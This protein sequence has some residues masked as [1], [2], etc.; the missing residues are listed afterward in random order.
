MEDGAPRGLSAWPGHLNRPCAKAYATLEEQGSPLRLTH[1]MVRTSPKGSRDP[2]WRRIGWDEAYRLIAGR[3]REVRERHG[4][5]SVMFYAGNPKEMRLPLSRLASAFGSANFATEDSLCYK[6]HVLASLLLFGVVI[7]A[8]TSLD[9]ARSVLLWGANPAASRP[10]MLPGLL[11]MRAR[12]ARFVVV[13]PR[14]TPTAERLADVHLRPLPGTDGALALGM[15]NV[16]ISREIYDREFV[17]RW[18]HGFDA[19]RE[20]VSRFTPERVEAM[21]RVPARDVE[22][23]AVLYASERPGTVFLG[24]A[25]PQQS[26]NGAQSYRAVLSLA[27]LAGNLDVPGGIALPTHPLLPYTVV[28]DEVLRPSDMLSLD[29]TLLSGKIEMRD[30]RADVDRVPVWAELIPTE[31]Q[32]NFLPEYVRDGVIRAGVFFGLN[33]A[34]WPDRQSYAA[35][36][37]SLEFSVA[38]DEFYRPWTHDH[39]DMVLPA[40]TMYERE[41]PFAVFG[42]RVYRRQRVLE[43]RGEARSD[44]RIIFELAVELGLGDRFWNGDTRAAMDWILRRAAGVGYEDVPI[45]EGKLIPPPG[46]EE[47]RKYERGLLRRD[48]RPGF[49]TP[50]GK[51]EVWS[52]VLERHG[53]D[54]L[55]AYVEPPFRPSADYPLI[56]MTALRD[57]LYTTGRHKWESGWVRDLRPGPAVDVNP[58]DADARGISEGDAVTV[59]T[60]RGRLMARAHLTYTMLSGVVGFYPGWSDDPRTDVNVVLPRVL[61]PISGYPDYTYICE[62][63]RGWE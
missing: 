20:Y 42:R 6:L 58:E 35:A 45:P 63:R 2:G 10:Y 21:T 50:T 60:P 18:V 5:D 52:T 59:V 36:L 13:D 55:P 12:G 30:R 24:I 25:A 61:D 14:R 11:R 43:P 56:L 41:E 26:T 29:F 8:Y 31:V 37:D 46:P 48:G 9:G 1:P 57:P 34:A 33:V 44:W 53:F 28:G 51:V 7:P 40:A 23:A 49:P 62:L 38:I 15:I 17:E 32:A 19:L 27:A 4:P 16:M 22:R 3:L 47:F 54:P 39:V